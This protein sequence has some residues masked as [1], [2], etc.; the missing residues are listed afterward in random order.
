MPQFLIQTPNITDNKYII[1]GEDYYHL[2]KARRVKIG[3]LLDLR[4]DNGLI[5]KGRIS[6]ITAESIIVEIIMADNKTEP[7]ID[8]SLYISLLK[9]KKFDL[10]LQ[11]A[12]EIGV[13]KIIPV[14]AERSIPDLS[15]GENK[16]KRWEKIV[17]EAFKQCM[18]KQIPV[19]KEVMT[20][21]EAILNNHSQI[22]IIAHP[23]KSGRNIREYLA[24]IKR[25][26]DIS[27]L[28]GPEGGFSNKELELA[29]ENNWDQIVF[30]FTSLRAE[31]AAIILPAI[32]IYEWS[33]FNKL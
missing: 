29:Q 31:T 3:E 18:R 27:I 30:G 21:K 2:K 15:T 14:L 8:L 19:I 4:G 17:S 9:G 12:T 6:K 7:T 16:K 26:V 1:E 33:S 22:K 24:G 5:Y 20:F 28:I 25:N 11:K 13:C 23:G 10:V 32:L